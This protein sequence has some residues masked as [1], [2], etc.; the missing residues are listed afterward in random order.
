MLQTSGSSHKDL[1]V[2]TEQDLH[3]E[4]SGDIHSM[5]IKEIERLKFE[6]E[7][8]V[9]ALKN[10]LEVRNISISKVC[11]TLTSWELE[12]LS[13]FIQYKSDFP[14]DLTLCLT[15]LH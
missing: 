13:F 8:E 11:F 15:R 9:K 1:P 10:L 2:K 5:R 14:S 6:K 12:L 4:T 7:I 3:C